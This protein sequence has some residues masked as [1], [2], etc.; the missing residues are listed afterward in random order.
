VPVQ[1]DHLDVQAL[2]LAQS[3]RI[4]VKR[5]C[6]QQEHTNCDVSA[7]E[8]GE[9][10]ERRP[11]RARGNREALVDEF[12]EL[13]YLPRQKHHSKQGRRNEPHPHLTPI[14]AGHRVVG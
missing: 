12:G 2:T 7:V 1:A 14:L 10:E 4:R 9:H 3:A 5:S 6:E 11:E 13:E 8:T